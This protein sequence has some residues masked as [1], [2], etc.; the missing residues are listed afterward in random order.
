MISGTIPSGVLFW[1]AAQMDENEREEDFFVYIVYPTAC[2]LGLQPTRSII[3]T[4][5]DLMTPDNAQTPALPPS[6]SEPPHGRLRGIADSIRQGV[7]QARLVWGLLWDRR[8]NLLLKLIPVAGIAYV[9][10]PL[11]F[12]PDF[13]PVLGQVDDLAIIMGSMWLFV[14]F[15]PKAIV[16]EHWQSLVGKAADGR[17]T[18]ADK[19]GE[20][21]IDVD[22]TGPAGSPNP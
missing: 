20:A 1:G 13:I 18:S 8:V 9:V 21:I 3:R 14:E 2:R 12:I 19:P 10:F 5:E 6:L 22:P 15:A 4:K 7:L 17:P 16:A 11:D